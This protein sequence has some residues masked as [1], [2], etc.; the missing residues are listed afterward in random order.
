MVR[1]TW[2]ASLAQQQNT[3]TK[4][5][6]MKSPSKSMTSS[7]MSARAK[8]LVPGAVMQFKIKIMTAMSTGTALV[9]IVLLRSLSA[10][11]GSSLVP[12]C[13]SGSLA[14][15]VRVR[16]RIYMRGQSDVRS[17]YGVKHDFAVCASEGEPF[18]VVC[19]HTHPGKLVGEM[20]PAHR[21]AVHV[22]QR[23]TS[24]TRFTDT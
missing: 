1:N 2:A 10:N 17:E 8:M 5:R 6:D 19:L 18:A 16:E 9:N 3:S 15:S 24:S 11:L 12:R 21:E 4:L 20:V 13:V 22:A 7:S 23:E 14:S